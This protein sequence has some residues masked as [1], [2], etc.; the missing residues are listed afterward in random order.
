MAREILKGTA[1]IGSLILGPTTSCDEEARF[2]KTIMLKKSPL[3]QQGFTLVEL[4]VVV[5][6]IGVL[7]GMLLPAVQMVRESARRTNC[8]NNLKQLGIAVQNYHDTKRFIPPSRPADDFLTWPVYLMPYIEQ[9]NLFDQFEANRLYRDQDPEI[10]R[11]GLVVMFCPSRRG[12]E[13][14]ESESRGEPVGACGDYAGNA[15]TSLYWFNDDWANFDVPVDGVF[16]SGYY[17]QNPVENNRLV[18]GE[19]GRYAFKDVLDGLSTTIFLGEKAVDRST[20]RQPGG[21]GDGCIY[22]GSEPG[23]CMRLG[24]I[25]F[26]IAST[27]EIGAP[28]PGAVPVFG[29]RILNSQT[30]STAM[31]VYGP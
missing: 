6:V 17:D 9:N 12:I 24:G 14:S 5:A 29:R 21:W 8:L 23:T 31:A 1:G 7:I 25:G 11:V 27:S 22:N 20:I 18:R 10:L 16:N 28:G 26:G 15:G 19:R 2:R 4:L 13:I 3:S 30:S